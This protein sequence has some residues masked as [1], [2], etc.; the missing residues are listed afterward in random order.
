V[1]SGIA[2]EA[3]AEALDQQ[4]QSAIDQAVAFAE[5]SPQ[6]DLSSLTDFVYA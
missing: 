1:R 5:A 6:P 2:S 3:E 4:A